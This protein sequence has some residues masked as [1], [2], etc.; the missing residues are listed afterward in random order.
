MATVISIASTGSVNGQRASRGQ[1]ARPRSSRRAGLKFTPSTL[2][3]G[4]NTELVCHRWTLDAAHSAASY[5]PG[6]S[7]FSSRNR[8]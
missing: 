4:R 8:H 3:P 1:L 6:L 2:G 5:D 7:I